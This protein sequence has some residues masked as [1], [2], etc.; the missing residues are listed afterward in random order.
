[1]GGGD[2]ALF[3]TYGTYGT[4]RYGTKLTDHPIQSYACMLVT[5]L[6]TVTA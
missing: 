3:I 5:I 1:M 4:V 6:N 2:F